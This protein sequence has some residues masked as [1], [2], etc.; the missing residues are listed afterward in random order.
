MWAAHFAVPVWVA[1]GPGIGLPSHD[2]LSTASRHGVSGF[3][4]VIRRGVL[5][6]VGDGLRK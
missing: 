5:G 2:G 1:V 3:S 6:T 4:C